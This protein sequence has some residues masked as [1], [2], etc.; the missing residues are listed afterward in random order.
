[1]LHQFDEILA[2]G[3]LAAG[4]MDLQHADFGELAEHLLPFLGRELAAATIQFDRI[5]AIGALQR[6]A[7]RQFGEHR[8]RNAERLR[9]R[10]LRFQNREP[11]TGRGAGCLVLGEEVAHDVFSRASVRKPLSARSCS[12]ATTSAAIASRGAAYLTAS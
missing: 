9:R 1:M 2:R 3:G 5:G 4:E 12:I 10:T 8:E 11:V 7:V 6:A